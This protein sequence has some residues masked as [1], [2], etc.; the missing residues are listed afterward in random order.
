[1]HGR[2]SDYMGNQSY[3]IP[4]ELMQFVSRDSYSLLIKGHAGTGK[5]TLALT[6]LKILKVVENFQ[7]ISTRISPMQL[8]Q[9]YPWLEKHFNTTKQ[10]HT[11][12]EDNGS[13][14]PIF[15]DARLDEPSS[16]FERITNQLMD[17]GSPMIIIDTWDAISYF[18]D[19]EAIMNN[20]RVLQTWRERA[21]AKMIFISDNPQDTTFDV[22][23]DGIVDLSQR[24]Q[25][26]RLLRD[27]TISKMRG[28]R[29]NYP[30]YKFTLNGGAFRSFEPYNPS[31]F[32]LRQVPRTVQKTVPLLEGQFIKSGNGDLD[33][34]IGGGFP[35]KT[36]AS[37][38]V[39][40]NVNWKA[41]LALLSQ[42]VSNFLAGGGSV[43]CRCSATE[44]EYIMDHFKAA[45]THP[46]A[47]DGITFSCDQTTK[48]QDQS[49]SKTM[50]TIRAKNP[51]K[52]LLSIIFSDTM[53]KITSQDLNEIRQ[54][55]SLT[56]AVNVNPTDDV[57]SM[58]SRYSDVSISFLDIGG[59][60]FLQSDMPWSHLFAV[61]MEK[62]GNGAQ[63]KL[64]PVV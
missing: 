64:E 63:I 9:Y 5:T 53:P 32:V 58:L 15:V 50:K 40:P 19:R 51:D 39:G 33:A 27:I 59:T 48:A 4:P 60:L 45:W 8:Y 44:K 37:I 43:L 52:L 2:E 26:D 54:H 7:Y 16:M 22:L 3:N 42:T 29:I 36:M 24:Y 41:A 57:R 47:A 55:S 6:I 13:E 31:D 49:L 35:L 56:V 62:T 17:V 11:L 25:G 1:M 23:V 34:A 46:K 14:M 20:A 18:M 10:P 12:D 61:T 38:N 28:I 30:S 21:R